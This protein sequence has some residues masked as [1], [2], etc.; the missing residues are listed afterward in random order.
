MF[1]GL[2]GAAHAPGCNANRYTL[3]KCLAAAVSGWTTCHDSSHLGG[4]RNAFV[5]ALHC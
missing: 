4:T 5:E 3:A 1:C 2:I